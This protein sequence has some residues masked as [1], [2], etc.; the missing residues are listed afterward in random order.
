M[1]FNEKAYVME[2]TLE[3]KNPDRIKALEDWLSDACGLHHIVM[4]PI[5]GDAS[6]RRYF[7]IHTSSNTYV[8]MDAPPPQENCRPFVAIAKALRSIGLLA[9]EIIGADVER[10]FLLLSD[11]GDWTYLKSLNLQNANQLYQSALTNLAAL[12]AL[13]E[14]PGRSIPQFTQDFMRQEWAWHKEWFLR[15]FLNL[16]LDDHEAALDACYAHI[17]E[18]AALQPQVFMHRD[19]HSANLMV[20]P[21]NQ[22]GIL[23]FQ[24]AFIGPVTYDLV[25][26]LRDCYIDWP[27]QHVTSW[28]LE[29]HRIL[30]EQDVLGDVSQQEFLRWFD[31]M[32][33]QRHLKAIFTFSRKHIR[34]QQSQYLKHIPRT[35]K[36]LLQV[37]QR[38]PELAPLYHYLHDTVQPAFERAMAC[39][40]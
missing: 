1:Q 22:V 34:D 15:N 30:I 23:D 27:Q 9:P 20:L 31:L 33:V 19:Y 14:V 37:S 29:Y 17:V 38:Y 3:L 11:F 28:A 26:L 32:G 4:Q 39:V 2:S 6:F 16:Q 21:G 10:G 25:S 13:R 12:Q 7:R 40:Q 24:D 35:L 36:Y 5:P 18:A 8:A